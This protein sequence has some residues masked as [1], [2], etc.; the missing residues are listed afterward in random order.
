ML[1]SWLIEAICMPPAPDAPPDPVVVLAVVPVSLPEP[2][3]VVLLA[4]VL[5]VEPADPLPVPVVPPL[6]E[7]LAVVLSVEPA[8][9]LPVVPPLVEV[10]AVVSAEPAEPPD[11]VAPPVLFAAKLWQSALTCDFCWSVS[12]AQLVRISSWDRNAEPLAS[13]KNALPIA[14]DHPL[15]IGEVVPVPP[16]PVAELPPPDVAVPEVLDP[17]VSDPE[18]VPL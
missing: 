16:E 8:D 11:P 3:V 15:G 7:L 12:D 5:S 18:A 17:E 13:V 2:P 4:V 6:V 10:L 9:P 1:H 14:P